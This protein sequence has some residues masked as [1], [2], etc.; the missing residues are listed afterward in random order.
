MLDR[1]HKVRSFGQ[2]L[3]YLSNTLERTYPRGLDAEIF[4]FVALERAY[5]DATQ[6]FEREHVTPYMYLHPESFS[7]HGFFSPVDLSRHRW[8]L[9]TEEDWQ[10]I[11]TIYSALYDTETLFATQAVVELMNSRPELGRINAHI[12]QKK[13]GQ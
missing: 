4:T 12:E 10:L 6:P 1:F 2:S 8:T 3:D 9:D 13:L 11:E 7:L 5:R